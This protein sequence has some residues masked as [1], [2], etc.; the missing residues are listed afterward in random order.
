MNQFNLAKRLERRFNLTLKDIK[1]PTYFELNNQINIPVNGQIP[2]H[3]DKEAVVA[4]LNENVKPNR[5]FTYCKG[6]ESNVKP[7]ESTGLKPMTYMDKLEW[8][9]KNDYYENDFIRKYT[10]QF[11]EKLRLW[12]ANQDFT[13]HSF[14]AAYK[15]Y[16]QYALKTNNG[17]YY[18]EDPED[19][20]L[21]N[22]L[23]QA[24]GDENL[25]KDLARVIITRRYQPATPTYANNGRKRRGEFASC[26]I[27][28][29]QDNM[30]D[31]GRSITNALQLSR[32]AGGVGLILGNLRAAG[33]PIKKMDGLASGV[34]PVMKLFEDSFSY[35]NQL[36]TR[37]GAGVAYLPIFH[38]DVM[39]FLSSKKENADE[40]IRLKTLSLGLTVPDKFYELTKANAKM[41]LFDPYF[42]EKELGKPFTYIDLDKEYEHLVELSKQIDPETGM[43]KI[44]VKWIE[45]RA[46]EQAISELQQESGYP[47][48]INISTANNA[49]PIEGRILGSNLCSEILQIQTP[50]VITEEQEYTTLGQD[51]V[52]NLGSTN[53][54]NMMAAGE[55]FGDDIIAMTKGLTFISDASDLSFV[56]TIDNGNSKNH[57]IGLGAMGLHSFLANNQIQYESQDAVDFTGLYFLAMNYYTLVG[58]NKIAKERNQTFHNFENSAYATGEYFDKYLTTDYTE[59]VSEKVMDLFKD[60]H[61]PSI[62]DWKALKSEIQ[63][64]GLFNAYRMAL[65]P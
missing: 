57:A 1:N 54:L 15:F 31:I 7:H 12:F 53:V 56:Q 6:Q 36:G 22:A 19:R 8:L 46:L 26:F 3:K 59:G 33:S 58:S 17:E 44:R 16:K 13:F 9:I 47:Y 5:L 24:N 41:A 49:N 38:S 40:K 35:S 45:A 2:L 4:F 52:C 14:M 30:S 23:Y 25:A 28:Q 50:S 42:V 61:L 20:A 39:E 10:P 48:I 27:I 18:L 11:I 32:K 62:E 51:I 64:Y 55:S 60:I 37:P 34:L 43:P 29:V 21:M 65:A 63:K